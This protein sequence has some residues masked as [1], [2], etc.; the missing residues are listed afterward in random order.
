[1]CH[2][3]CLIEEKFLNAI[4]VLNQDA[5]HHH[6]VQS[7]N[8]DVNVMLDISVV[9]MVNVFVPKSVSLMNN[10]HLANITTNVQTF[11][12]NFIAAQILVAVFHWR[13]FAINL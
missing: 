4:K 7:V 8:Q 9:M 10:V 12:M 6:A 5:V 3:L 11:V 2:I 13:K 1:M